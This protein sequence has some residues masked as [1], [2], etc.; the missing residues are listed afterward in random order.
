VSLI[1]ALTAVL[2]GTCD[3]AELH[4]DG[5]R[6]RYDLSAAE[7]TVL[8]SLPTGE[9]A[10]LRREIGVKRWELLTV[11][12]STTRI[13]AE[14]SGGRLRD[15]YLSGTV[16]PA[17][18]VGRP[19]WLLQ[20]ASHLVG[21]LHGRPVVPPPVL[22]LAD[23]ELLLLELSED[24]AAST[25]A[26]AMAQQPHPAAAPAAGF[27]P[28]LSA[29]VRVRTFPYDVMALAAAPGADV[30]VRETGVL[31]R[32]HWP[33]RLPVITRAGV[34]I[35]NLLGR[36]DGRA[37]ARQVAAASPDPVRAAAAL[38]TLVE[39]KILVSSGEA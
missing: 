39:R 19:G 31:I 27:R 22:A 1:A 25:A 32:K 30:A 36:C 17:G 18:V 10:H 6:A 26:R 24:E 33:H 35:V 3:P 4:G 13:L 8:R 5:F 15:A 11:L 9:L 16:R 28:R 7:L 38:S 14:Q 21:W 34:G 23:F 37:T 20:E 29:A 2:G 12:P